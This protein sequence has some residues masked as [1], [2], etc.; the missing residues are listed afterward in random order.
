MYDQ[1][2]YETIERYL[3]GELPEN[4]QRAFAERLAT[5]PALAAEV[6]LHRQLDAAIGDSE[7]MEFF[8]A[9]QASEARYFSE[10]ASESA[11]ETSDSVRRPRWRTVYT[12]AAAVLILAVV[13]VFTLQN[14][15][16]SSPEAL[17]QEYFTVYSGAEWRSGSPVLETEL[18]A[19]FSVYQAQD[20]A[21]AQTA[22]AALE[23]KSPDNATV[24]FYHAMSAMANRDIATALP[25]LRGLSTT[26]GHTFRSQAQWY[27]ALAY[28]N[29]NQ[30]E[31]AIPLLEALAAKPGKYG[32]LARELQEEL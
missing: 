17:Y 23:A 26:S 14:L 11:P 16:E 5:E 21:A 18:K 8:A 31:S 20:Y 1:A 2:T 22:F 30:P 29:Q 3:R 32:K 24:R 28:L 25:R 7:T 4:E 6:D 27:L 10:T 9:A 15:G 12:I 19:A 13:G